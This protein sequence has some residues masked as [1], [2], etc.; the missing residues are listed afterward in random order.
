M[1]KIVINGNLTPENCKEKGFE[2]QRDSIYDP[3]AP[4]EANKEFIELMIKGWK[5][6]Q[7][8]SKELKKN[9]GIG[10]YKPIKATYKKLLP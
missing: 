9:G 5:L 8:A 7:P 10:I 2:W 3:E 6:G 1:I 4:S